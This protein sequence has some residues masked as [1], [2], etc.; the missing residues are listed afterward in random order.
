MTAAKMC[1]SLQSHSPHQE[2]IALHHGLRQ[3]PH[4]AVQTVHLPYLPGCRHAT[5]AL[6][7]HKLAPGA[8]PV[9]QERLPAQSQ[10]LKPSQTLTL[11]KTD[12]VSKHHNEASHRSC[13]GED[14]CGATTEQK[15]GGLLQA[16]IKG[17]GSDQQRLS[18]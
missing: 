2:G 5:S 8:M 17:D 14:T 9:T 18:Q 1:G 16:C 10:P 4:Q 13:A 6:C 3:M 15:C 12:P 7:A 11:C